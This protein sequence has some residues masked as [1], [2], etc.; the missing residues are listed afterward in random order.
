MKNID[1]FKSLLSARD[2]KNVSSLDQSQ[3]CINFVVQLGKSKEDAIIF[4]RALMKKYKAVHNSTSK[5]MTKH[6]E[7][8]NQEFSTNT[9]VVEPEPAKRAGVGRP[10]VDFDKASMK[11]KKRRSEDIVQENTL[12][13]IL[14]AAS[15]A[16][17]R[18]GRPMD[19]K[20]YIL[21]S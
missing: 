3:E 10:E 20:V 5:M 15:V 7:W 21:I 11:T 6:A 17:Y 9:H 4:M 13:E 1:V 12:K 2:Q 19:A 14:M 18:G 16:L 8:L